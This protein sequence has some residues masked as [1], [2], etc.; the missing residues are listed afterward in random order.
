MKEITSEMSRYLNTGSTGPNIS[1]WRAQPGHLSAGLKYVCAEDFTA[2]CMNEYLYVW[3]IC[4]HV[5]MYVWTTTTYFTLSYTDILI[6]VRIVRGDEL[7][8]DVDLAAIEHFPSAGDRWL[9]AREV[10]PRNI[11][12]L[13]RYVS[14]KCQPISQSNSLHTYLLYA[15]MYAYMYICI[16]IFFYRDFSVKI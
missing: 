4:M 16:W 3:Y 12:I 10:E 2:L 6:P 13:L 5:C 14:W 7:L 1:S 15:C 11:M 8:F 9:Y